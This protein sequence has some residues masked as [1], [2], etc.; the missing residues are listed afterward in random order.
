MV[1]VALFCGYDTKILKN[2]GQVHHKVSK[3]EKKLNYI[4]IILLVLLIVMCSSC[5]VGYYFIHTNNNLRNANS[6]IPA[7][8]FSLL[9]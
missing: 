7:V 4:Q 3:V 6:Y 1:G 5:G 8:D 9:L 2:Q